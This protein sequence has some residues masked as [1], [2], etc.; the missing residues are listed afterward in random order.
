[1]WI[2]DAT[3]H[4]A[5]SVARRGGTV[6]MQYVFEIFAEWMFLLWPHRTQKA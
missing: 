6:A 3:E 5:V 4:L 1:L 2:K